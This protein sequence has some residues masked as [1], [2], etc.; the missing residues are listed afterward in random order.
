MPSPPQARVPTEMPAPAVSVYSAGPWLAAARPAP[1]PADLFLARV[2]RQPH[3]HSS[4]D[5]CGPGA[6]PRGL[7]CRDPV[8]LPARRGRAGPRAPGVPAPGSGPPPAPGAA[9]GR[10]H[11]P[12]EP[13]PQDEGGYVTATPGV[14]PF[15]PSR[16]GSAAPGGEVSPGPLPRAR[17]RRVRGAAGSRRGFMS[18]R[19]ARSASL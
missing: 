19:S 11:V 10:L 17:G 3:K 6:R 14:H 8:S 9:Q 12:S 4:R 16:G 7:R 15:P 18:R 1:A 2:S 5:S 13:G